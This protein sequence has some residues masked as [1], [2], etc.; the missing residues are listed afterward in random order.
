[1]HGVVS[2]LDDEHYALVEQI[3]DEL[4]ERFGVR[5]VYA[6]PF[7]HF[8]YHVAEAYQVEAV[9]AALR[10]LAQS[11][12]PFVLRTAGLGIFGAD[13][14]V[15]Y[16]PV[17]RSP[18]L[19]ALHEEVWRR[20]SPLASGAMRYYDPDMWMP[21]ITLAHGD[22]GHEQLAQIVRALSERPFHWETRLNNLSMI[23][24]TGTEQGLRCR[25]NFNGGDGG[26]SSARRPRQ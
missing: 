11:A 16:I 19:S 18:E 24:D 1:M 2:L 22:I 15:L 20:V 12:S 13:Q 3:W 14:P 8:S 6:K 21:H 4:A 5:G 7:P 23:Y 25:F 9:E 26:A 17:V 10:G